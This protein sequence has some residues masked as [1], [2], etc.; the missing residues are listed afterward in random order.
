MYRLGRLLARSNRYADLEG[1][2]IPSDL[3]I[4]ISP[5][6]SANMMGQISGVFNTYTSFQSQVQAWRQNLASFVDLTLQDPVTV[7]EIINVQ[8]TDAQTIV[9]GLIEQALADSQTVQRSTVTL[10]SV[11]APTTPANK[12]TGWILTTKILDGTSA[13][14][15]DGQANINYR[16]LSS[17]MAV[18]GET[19]LFQ[20]VSDSESGSASEGGESWTWYGALPYT[21]FDWHQEGSGIGPG[22]TTA[23]GISLVQ[24]GNFENWTNSTTPSNWTIAAGSALVGQETSTVFRGSSALKITGD[25][26]TAAATLTQVPSTMIN[27]TRYCVPVQ[28]QAS[29]VPAAGRLLIQFTGTGYSAA[30]LTDTVQTV[31]VSGTPTG[32][33]YTLSWTGP[34]GG[35]QTTAHIA[36]NANAAAVQSALRALIGLESVVV[37]QSGSTPNFTNTITFYGVVGDTALLTVTDATTG[38][39]HAIAVAKTV[40][41]VEGEQIKLPAT[42][43]PTGGW[44]LR[45]FWI[46]TPDI[47]PS[48]WALSISVD[49]TLSNTVKV[50]LDSLQ[51]VQPTYHGGV[52]AVATPGATRWLNGDRLTFTVAN[53]EGIFQQFFR[54]YYRAQMPSAASPTISDTLAVPPSFIVDTFTDTNG[55]DITAHTINYGSLSWQA[56]HSP[57]TGATALHT[58]QTNAFQYDQNGASNESPSNAAEFGF[59][60]MSPDVFEKVDVSFP[61]LDGTYAGALIRYQD[62]SNFTHATLTTAGVV[63]IVEWIYGVAYSRASTAGSGLSINTNYPLR[64]YVRGNTITIYGNGVTA[65]WAN[66]TAAP[67]ATK[68]GLIVGAGAT[69]SVVNFDNFD[70]AAL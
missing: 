10:G 23:D 34:Y 24:D 22:L 9:A 40:T 55:V 8:S 48:D 19:M 21:V 41:G 18:P 11:T 51:V 62:T 27:R 7:G 47:V 35:A 49:S 67:Y 5:Y 25:G 36:Y 56:F 66:A 45:Y 2:L 26:A 13:P 70:A 20:V 54:Q 52:G 15:Q 3:N 29:S 64:V 46:N 4:I 60:F 17:E 68:H 14:V 33:Y 1:F 16:G 50:Y 57:T 31:T 63:Q 65:T 37:S 28:V 43:M 42:A 53:A 12:G 39:S 38:G 61:S 69:S 59:D 32:G 58:I 6:Q 44:A 30:S